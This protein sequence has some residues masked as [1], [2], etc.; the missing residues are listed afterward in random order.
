M[1]L[2]LDGED[3]RALATHDVAMSAARAVLAAQRSGAVALPP[4]LDVD[5]PSGFLRVMPAAL[6][7]YMGLKVMSLAESV[8][9][10]YLILVYE[11]DSG[12]LIAVIDAEEVTRQRT[13]ATT[14]VAGELLVPAGAT[15]LGLVGSG[16]EAEG[17]LRVFARQWPLQRVDVFSPTPERRERFA[18]RMSEELGIAVRPVDSVQEATASAP[19]SVLCTKSGKPVVDGTAFP[20]GAVVLSIGSTRPD[21][22]E[23]DEV[24]LRRTAAL[25]VD[26]ARQVI[27]ESGDISDALAGEALTE[28]DIVAMPDWTPA[29][30]IVTPDRDLLTFKSVGTALQDLALAG[31]LI[32]AAR[33]TGRGRPLGEISRLK[34]FAKRAAA[35]AEDPA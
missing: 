23:L 7:P 20:P 21:L 33:A 6:H 11:Q 19:V 2:F 8:G 1:T 3:V 26:D 24:T 13:A 22:R 28:G 30:A 16:F 9:T 18:A 29:S 14:A 17:H 4:R 27:L 15:H 32:S 34:P 25:L 5:L 31:E 10:R 35:L 12:E